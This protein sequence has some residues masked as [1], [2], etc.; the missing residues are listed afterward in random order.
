MDYFFA[1][2][3]AFFL[4]AAFFLVLAAGLL[5]ADLVPL[6]NT[7]AQPSANFLFVPTRTIVTGLNLVWDLGQ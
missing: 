6:P 5:L 4:G 2:L 1:F 3:A 7:L